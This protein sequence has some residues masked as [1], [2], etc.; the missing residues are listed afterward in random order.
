MPACAE[1]DS[2]PDPG[3]ASLDNP[4]LI[5]GA[6]RTNDLKGDGTP[7][8]RQPSLTYYGGPM[9]QAPELHAVFWGGQV[10]TTTQA[11]I[12][13]FFGDLA[14]STVTPMLGQYD[15]A[16][17]AQFITQ[18]KYAGS[19][20][21]ADAPVQTTITDQDIQVE[22]TRMIDTGTLPAN[23]GNRLYVMYVPPGATVHTDFGDS[24]VAFCGYHGS[25][26]RNGTN[27]FYAVLPDMSVDPC[28]TACAYDPTPINDTY[29][30]TSHEVTEATTDA[31]VGMTT[32]GAA[33]YAWLDPLTGNEIGD[34]CAGLSFTSAAGIMEQTEWS[35]AAQGCVGATPAAPSAIA[36]TPGSSTLPVNGTVKLQVVATGSSTM[37]LGTFS[38]P[39]G[40]TAAIDPPQ[41][42]GGQVATIT[43]TSAGALA[44]FAEFG[45]Y[46]VD[47]NN[48][49]HL[50]Y[51]TLTVQGAAPT[52]TGV[53]IAGQT[54]PATGP[55]AGGQALVLTGTNL[56]SV[57]TVSFGGTAAI[58]STISASA[59]GTQLFVTTP[60]HAAGAVYVMVSSADGQTATI[61]NAYTYTASPAP[62][63]ASAS[64]AIGPSR[65]GRKLTLTGTGFGSPTVTFGGV[66]ATITSS[67]ATSIAL[68]EPAHAAGATDITVVN[69][70]G[71]SA[72]LPAAYTFA[73]VA[74][75]LLS[76]VTQKVGP[77]AGGQYL[78]IE[79][80]DLVGLS[81]TVTFGD[82]PATVV[83]VGPTFIAVKTPAH[84]AGA[85]DVAITD[86]TQTSTLPAAY[87][88]Q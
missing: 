73:D 53:T 25:F 83:S 1:T 29:L 60:G 7:Q 41:I 15:T 81:P 12:N 38:L 58:A 42:S 62:T 59:D 74:P 65:G 86:G 50:A 79:L 72:S 3:A 45:A 54:T 24:C 76:L 13:T 87:T 82:V 80:G 30:A 49:V 64:A 70:D 36:V 31:A 51:V 85:V 61:A 43:L 34:I 17:P 10:P 71:Q 16:S 27:A 8:A 55:S 33:S 18:M 4:N 9:L 57:R 44:S 68:L 52:V 39:A 48:T 46:A 69:G 2:P 40:V 67:T 78:T 56:T 6:G 22:L 47:A 14:Q 23:D 5:H 11:S 66:A 84:A 88:F 37:S 77:A 63:L 75:P 20:I 28:R 32:S 26:Y 35:N 21:D 19:T